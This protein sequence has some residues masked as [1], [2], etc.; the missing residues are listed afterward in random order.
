VT[1]AERDE[2]LPEVP[3]IAE[4]GFSGF[5]TTAWFA[6][7]ISR[8]TPDQLIATIERDVIEVMKSPDV[9]QKLV[10]AGITPSVKGSPNWTAISSFCLQHPN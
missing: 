10:A 3:T 8:A 7:A 2:R 1:S 6:V 9:V 4:Q 5:E